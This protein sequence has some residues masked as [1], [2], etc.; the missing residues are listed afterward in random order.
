MQQRRSLCRLIAYTGYS[1]ACNK[2][3][4]KRRQACSAAASSLLVC[5]G[6]AML[7]TV[8]SAESS[9]FQTLS[10]S[11]EAMTTSSE[12][13]SVSPSPLLPYNIA[14]CFV[15]FLGTLT[16]GFVLAGFWLSDRSKITSS[17]VHIVNHTTLEHSIIFIT[18]R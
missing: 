12:W 1:T 3:R 17:S 6:S 9:E 14:L 7:S 16:N 15:G 10:Y 18:L 5:T 11:S 2:I 4:Y 8:A 13:T